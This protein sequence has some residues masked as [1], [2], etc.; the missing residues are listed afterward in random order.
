MRS[1]VG[2]ELDD[3]TGGDQFVERVL[4]NAP[5]ASKSKSGDAV[6]SAAGEVQSDLVV[7]VRP[8][9]TKQA[10]S[11]LNRQQQRQI[12]PIIGHTSRHASLQRLQVVD[13]LS[14]AE[15]AALVGRSVEA[16]T[17]LLARARQ[18][19]RTIVEADDGD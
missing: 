9:D 15:V 1:R 12:V 14:V 3:A 18:R 8:T 16:T 5:Q 2:D 11:L 10:G 17:S 19:L 4:G 7:R 13:E 6:A